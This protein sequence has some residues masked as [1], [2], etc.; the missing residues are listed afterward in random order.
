MSSAALR[1]SKRVGSNSSTGVKSSCESVRIRARLALWREAGWEFYVH[2]NLVRSCETPSDPTR[3]AL[4][5]WHPGKVAGAVFSLCGTASALAALATCA[6]C[7]VCAACGLPVILCGCLRHLSL[8]A[9]ILATLAGLSLCLADY[10]ASCAAVCFRAVPRFLCVNASQC[11][12]SCAAVS[13]SF[14]FFSCISLCC[15][16]LPVLHSHSIEFPAI[17]RPGLAPC[18]AAFAL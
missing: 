13:S 17:D 14:L 5:P 15:A 4:P 18:S 1:W 10:L 11:S 9:C 3:C 8:F 2:L 12:T 7:A 16:G 6:V